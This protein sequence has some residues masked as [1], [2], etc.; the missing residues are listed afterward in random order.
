M[1]TKL[2]MILLG[3]GHNH[4]SNENALSYKKVY[5][6]EKIKEGKKYIEIPLSQIEW[7]E[8]YVGTEIAFL[9][10]DKETNQLVIEEGTGSSK[11]FYKAKIKMNT[12]GV[13][14]QFDFLDIKEVNDKVV[15][16]HKSFFSKFDI[17]MANH[18]YALEEPSKADEL[19]VKHMFESVRKG[20][21]IAC[22]VGEKLLFDKKHSSFREYIKKNFTIESI[23]SLPQ[24]VFNPYTDVKT[25]I[26][27]FKKEK[28]PYNH[29]TWMV[30][31]END[32]FDLN[33]TRVPI[34]E[35]DI[36]KIRR[37][38]ENW[39]GYKI[40][41]ENDNET[42][43][44]YH[45]EEAG[46]AEFHTLDKKNWCVKRYNTPLL[47]L[48]SNH[49]LVP[50]KNLL[51]RVKDT[52]EIQN[53][54]MYKRVTIQSKAKGL[55]LR[56][57]ELGEKIGTKS[58]F[59]I[60]KNQFLISKIDARNGAYGIVPKELNSAIIT[61]N[62]WTYEINTDLVLPEFLIYL[63]KHDFFAQMCSICSYGSTNRWY[64]DEDTFYNFKIPLPSK[65][66]QKKIYQ[67]IEKI[68]KA[69][70]EILNNE[71]N[72]SKVINDIVG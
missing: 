69:K 67:Y 63:M 6:L 32:G 36:P 23:I 68:E 57:I 8:E 31:I 7:K 54:T 10:Y 11:V 48:N 66:E 12:D 46:F 51:F 58:Q 64:L 41:D 1:L 61:G 43:K 4:I 56:D 59:L 30:Q 18:P 65:E 15:D 40:N 20:G 24:G 38:W 29:K 34:T 26:L 42:F 25:S 39:G 33:S 62:F 49:D 44:S 71:D 19:F 17:V 45:K 27:L 53:N 72:I 60:K 50:I 37:L 14:P 9:P 2:N 35:N 16:Y 47:S 22:I 52:I 5:K 70:Q 55:S 13:N 3:D 28:T 21:K